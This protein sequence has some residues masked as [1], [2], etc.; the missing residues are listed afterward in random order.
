MAGRDL[1][2][3]IREVH[4]HTVRDKLVK[5]LSCL[6]TK[7][8]VE[9]SAVLEPLDLIR[10][11]AYLNPMFRGYHQHDSQEFL[12]CVLD[13]AH[14]ALKTNIPNGTRANSIHPGKLEVSVI[15]HLFRGFM[16]SSVECSR[17]NNVSTVHDPFFDLS[18][19]IPS[20]NSVE[21]LWGAASSLWKS[22]SGTSVSL[23]K[24]F[25]AFCSH[26]SLVKLDQ[27]Y[28]E[29]CN[30]KVNAI[31]KLEISELPKV[32][33][34]HIK[35]FNHNSFWGS[36]I[37]THIEFDVDGFD[38]S[39]FCSDD[40]EQDCTFD[41][42][43]VVEHIGSVSGGHYVAYAKHHVN[44]SWLKFDDSKVSKVTIDDVKSCQAYLLFYI[45]RSILDKS[46]ILKLHKELSSTIS[47]GLDVQDSADGDRLL[48]SEWIESLHYLGFLSPID[49]S[50]FCCRHG[51]VD[52]HVFKENFVKV[53]QES[54]SELVK[55]YGCLG[56]ELSLSEAKALTTLS[57]PECLQDRKVLHKRRVSLV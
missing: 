54:W 36:K 40:Q 26:E 6:Y 24:C 52:R 2:F 45:N 42:F 47:L 33:C 5:D 56:P 41:L 30:E 49:N 57:C 32:L 22:I 16:K 48:S 8:W 3:K 29:K 43:G 4:A 14:E 7:S 55:R 28:C 19:E 39:P 18:L 21:S 35:R 46:K 15:S 38:T 27:Y 10:D 23:D 13:S 51:K 11:I 34:I 44:N 9:G 17:C 1:Y 50:S 31:K 12:R 20:R 25:E 37:S 53:S